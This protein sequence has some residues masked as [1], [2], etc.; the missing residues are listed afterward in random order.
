LL[1]LPL[2]YVAREP[3]KTSAGPEKL[4]GR[5]DIVW[6]QG[7]LDEAKIRVYV[8]YQEK[9]EQQAGQRGLEF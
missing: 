2:P 3:E 1:L 7:G 9:R 5:A 6:T 8:R 4:A